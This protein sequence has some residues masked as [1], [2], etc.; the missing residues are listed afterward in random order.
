[1]LAKIPSLSTFTSAIN[2]G[3]NP[4]VNIVPVLEN[5]PYVVFAPNNDA[6]AELDPAA[7]DDVEDR[8]RPR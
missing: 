8:S 5:G 7:L 6:F 3:L 2:G 1:M 4:A